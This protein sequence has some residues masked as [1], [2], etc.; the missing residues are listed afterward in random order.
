MYTY[1]HQFSNLSTARIAGKQAP[2]KAVLL[3]SIM[4]LIA[5]GDIVNPNFILTE[6]L[7]ETFKREWRL[8]VRTSVF[9]PKVATP[10]WHMQSEP[11]Y[12]LSLNNGQ[13]ISNIKPRYTA[14]WLRENTFATI[15]QKLFALM[16][17]EYARS[18]FRRVLIDTYLTDTSICPLSSFV[19]I[20]GLLFNLTA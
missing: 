15:D 10:F 13:S 19:L 6:K 5:S 12:Q 4:D 20:F 11:F 16:K 3:L 17:D 9:S 14:S 7:E 8:F 1:I 2:H 18:E